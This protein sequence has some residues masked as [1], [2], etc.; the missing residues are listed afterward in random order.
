MGKKGDLSDFEHR[1]VVVLRR[2]DLSISKTADLLGFP[3]T[4]ISRFTE[5]DPKKRKYPVSSSVNENALLMSEARGEWAD[6]LEIIESNSSKH[7][8][9]P[10]YAEDHL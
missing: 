8:L 7:S 10:R 6:W 3:H 1:I 4:T 2:A 9:Q 5:N